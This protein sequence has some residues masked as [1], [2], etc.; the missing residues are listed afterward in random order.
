[1]NSR[2]TT[3][4]STKREDRILGTARSM[5]TLMCKTGDVRF[6]KNRTLIHQR[7]WIWYNFV[8]YVFFISLLRF[9]FKTNS[10]GGHQTCTLASTI[11][12]IKILL[13]K[14]NL[15]NMIFYI[16]RHGVLGKTE[17]GFSWKEEHI[18]FA[19]AVFCSQRTEHSEPELMAHML[20]DS[21]MRSR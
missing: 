2:A 10:W 9:C 5:A 16:K 14:I 1:M 4:H 18:V 8:C 11:I 7:C 17:E 20:C 15:R 13:E 3:I 12:Y 19:F 21:R 6:T